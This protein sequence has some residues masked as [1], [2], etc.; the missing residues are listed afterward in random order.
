MRFETKPESVFFIGITGGSCAGK[1]EFAKRLRTALGF[2]YCNILNQDAYYLD[3]SASF[4]GDG[5]VNFDA[6]ESIDFELLYQHLLRLQRNEP[7]QVPIYD[8]GSHKRFSKTK[9]LFSAN[10]I[11]LEGELIF[12]QPKIRDLLTEC[13]FI[14]IP[15]PTRLSRR[16]KRDMQERGR[17]REGVILQF[18][19]HVRPMHRRY[20]EPVKQLAT[21]IVN[22]DFTAGEVIADIVNKLGID[23]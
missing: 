20:I 3:Q 5:S 21:Y 11:L 17:Q 16:P 12:T 18:E 9:T 23:S 10:I 6:P 2:E 22:N 8:F 7:I 15:E 19:H 13:V 1:T 4:K 14:D